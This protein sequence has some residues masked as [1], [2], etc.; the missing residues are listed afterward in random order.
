[1]SDLKRIIKVTDGPVLET[2]TEVDAFL[3]ELQNKPK[4][5]VKALLQG[6]EINPDMLQPYKL[7]LLGV[8]EV[9]EVI[10]K[11]ECFNNPLYEDAD[12]EF[13]MDEETKRDDGRLP[14]RNYHFLLPFTEGKPI[15][16]EAQR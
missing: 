2:K 4:R 6:M 9:P 8:L 11:G 16:I 13:G 7:R 5:D 12:I 1:M 14:W 3:A 10:Y 15:I